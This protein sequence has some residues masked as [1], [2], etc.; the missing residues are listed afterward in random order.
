MHKMFVYLFNNNN[1]KNSF[2]KWVKSLQYCENCLLRK[3]ELI[4]LSPT[5]EN[6]CNSVVNSIVIVAFDQV[7]Q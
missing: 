2:S 3:A 7:R 5:L 1:N 4:S 6:A